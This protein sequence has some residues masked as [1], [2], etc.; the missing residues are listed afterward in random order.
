MRIFVQKTDTEKSHWVS[1]LSRRTV[2]TMQLQV[3][4]VWETVQDTDWAHQVA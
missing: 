1:V 2:A 3:K 4:Y